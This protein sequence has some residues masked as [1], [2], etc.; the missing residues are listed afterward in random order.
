MRLQRALLPSYL[1]AGLWPR[2][3]LLF[4]VTGE[5]KDKGG[6]VTEKRSLLVHSQY[7][8]MHSS[9][10]W[11]FAAEAVSALTIRMNW[12]VCAGWSGGHSSHDASCFWIAEASSRDH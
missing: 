6:C 11:S 12:C 4:P 7:I 10:P 5:P 1:L 3:C 2:D 9:C 8:G